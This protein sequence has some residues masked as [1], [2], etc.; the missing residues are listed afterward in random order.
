MDK[1]IGRHLDR[2]EFKNAVWEFFRN[3]INIQPNLIDS[4]IK[5]LNGL[6]HQIELTDCYRFYSSSLLIMYEADNRTDSDKSPCLDIRMIDFARISLKGDENN[7]HVGP[8]RGFMLGLQTII[9]FLE[10]LKHE[11]MKSNGEL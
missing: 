9:D 6:L 3:G 1:Y 7:F 8:D 2:K 4:T 10:E 5:K 11:L